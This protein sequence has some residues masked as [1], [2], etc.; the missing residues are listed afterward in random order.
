MTFAAG[1]V[2]SPIKALRFD[3]PLLRTMPICASHC[4]ELAQD[5]P[6]DSRGAWQ[7]VKHA[8]GNCAGR[9]H[10]QGCHLH[11]CQAG[12]LA[13]GGRA[14]AEQRHTSMSPP[15]PPPP[16]PASHR[17]YFR[18]QVLNFDSFSMHTPRKSGNQKWSVAELPILAAL[19]TMQPEMSPKEVG[20]SLGGMHHTMVLLIEKLRKQEKRK[21]L[22]VRTDERD[23]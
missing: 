2:A 22:R 23:H 6:R 1:R 16:P 5:R 14:A 18:D 11:P 13:A 4:S 21:V 7:P 10:R 19:E 20:A 8:A 3:S 15:P 17:P 12:G 9:A